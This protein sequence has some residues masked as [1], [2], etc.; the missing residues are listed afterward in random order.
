MQIKVLSWLG[1]FFPYLSLWVEICLWIGWVV[2]FGGFKYFLL[3]VV[4]GARNNLG[5]TLLTLVLIS[6]KSNAQFVYGIGCTFL[7]S[8]QVIL[9]HF[10]TQLGSLKTCRQVSNLLL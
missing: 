4:A 2:S 1:G 5:I 6:L 7:N 10:L 9:I 3:F 8:T